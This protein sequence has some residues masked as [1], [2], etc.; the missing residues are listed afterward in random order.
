MVWYPTHATSVFS[1]RYA[2]VS[3]LFLSVMLH[4]VASSVL[5]RC[6]CFYFELCSHSVWH[7]VSITLYKHR[8]VNSNLLYRINYLFCRSSCALLSFWYVRSRLGLH[9]QCERAMACIYVTVQEPNSSQGQRSYWCTFSI[10]YGVFWCLF[11]RV[12]FCFFVTNHGLE[13]TTSLLY[14]VLSLRAALIFNTFCLKGVHAY[15]KQT[16]KKKALLCN[17]LQGK[18]PDICG[19]AWKIVSSFLPN[20]SVHIVSVGGRN[21]KITRSIKFR[22]RCLRVWLHDVTVSCTVCIYVLSYM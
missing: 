9:E 4:C 19:I 6:L 2:S 22:P 3:P 11:S 13:I 12:R 5:N 17:M 1:G 8:Y 20:L 14:I 10:Y 21:M 18:D 7:N 15:L 16:N